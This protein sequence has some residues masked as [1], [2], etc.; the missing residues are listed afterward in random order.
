MFMMAQTV[1]RLDSSMSSNETISW[2]HQRA[3]TV[4]LGRQQ[5]LRLS[6]M[7]PQVAFRLGRPGSV[8]P[9]PGTSYLHV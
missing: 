8:T 7:I 3:E 1:C 9:I 6:S 4:N 2:C 5:T